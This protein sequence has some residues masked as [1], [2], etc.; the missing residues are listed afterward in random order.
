MVPTLC[1]NRSKGNGG[2]EK[3]S[4]SL[5]QRE[6]WIKVVLVMHSTKQHKLSDHIKS[7]GTGMA[8][9]VDLLEN[10]THEDLESSGEDYMS[11]LRC[12]DPDNPEFLSLASNVKIPILLST[13][14]FIPLYGG[15]ERHK[16]LALF[17]PEDLITAVALFLADQ[18]WSID[19]IMRT[20]VPSREGLL[21]VNSIGERV[22]L[23]VLNKMIYR[24]QEMEGN[25]FPFLCH[26]SDDYAKI[27]WKNG[28]AI[29]F[30]SVK[31]PG[32][33]CNAFLTQSY[34]LPVLDTM[35]VRKKHR[36]KDFGLLILED[37]VD[38]FTED[39]LGLRFPL[40]SFMRVACQKYFEQYPGDH[41]LLWEIEGTGT[42]HQRKTVAS[43]LEKESFKCI[44][45]SQKENIG[46][47]ADESFLQTAVNTTSEQASEPRE[48]QLSADAHKNKDGLEVFEG[49]SEELNAAQLFARSRGNNLRRPKLGK[50]FQDP[51][52]IED[53]VFYIP[54]S[55]S[56]PD[57]RVSE[58]SEEVME[59]E[60][61]VVESEQEVLVE[62]QKQP[63]QEAPQMCPASEKQDDKEGMEVEPLNGELVED[64]IKV[65]IVAEGQTGSEVVDGESKLQLENPEETTLTLLVPLILDSSVKSTEDSDDN[66]SD[67]V[68]SVADAELPPEEEQ[69]ATQRKRTLV[70]NADPVA[71]A[72]KEEPSNNGLSN[73]VATAEALEDT[74]SENVSP[75][76]TSSVE[77]QSEE[78]GSDTPEAPVVLGQGALVMVELED[79][80]Y[81][82]H[83]EGQKNQLDE[84]SE[85]SAEPAS[86]KAADSSSED[87]EIEVPVVDRRTLRRK[88]KGYKGPP[89]KKGKLI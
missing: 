22:V 11:D 31:L 19:D 1:T 43:I 40:T 86:E 14:G 26:G 65:S 37:F 15:E 36:G 39:A 42:L 35:F 73:S 2:Q 48:T 61:N 29:G 10:Y 82:H 49:T 70:P 32:S 18:W 87:V 81:S 13:V 44:E 51:E 88:A 23:Y 6:K 75:N 30:Y 63:A 33:I 27:L 52:S 77:E 9:P 62:N 21:Q 69:Q 58:S 12:G 46:S 41:Y 34:Q 64:A 83:P 89:K 85:E 7:P 78:G 25:E 56:E 4:F 28:E 76:T 74:I 17:A 8:F 5:F 71:A 67:K 84:Q 16:V 72:E 57:A 45:G 53:E 50:R 38:S 47:Q 20:S 24:Q 66:V 79:I 80:S 59:M 60:E 3:R 68:D 54:E 55:R